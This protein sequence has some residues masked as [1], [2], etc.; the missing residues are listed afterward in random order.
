M[1][2]EELESCLPPAIVYYKSKIRIVLDNFISEDLKF[3]N[4]LKPPVVPLI[5][6]QLNYKDL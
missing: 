2:F 5:G 3:F 6:G 1:A 4:D